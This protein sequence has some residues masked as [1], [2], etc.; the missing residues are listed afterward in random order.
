MIEPQTVAI[1]NIRDRISADF[2]LGIR[3][4]YFVCFED[5][6]VVKCKNTNITINEWHK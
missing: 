2:S 5:L 3:Y 1:P 4:H 6:M